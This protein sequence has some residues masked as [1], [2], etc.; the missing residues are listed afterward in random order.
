MFRDTVIIEDTIAENDIETRSW[1][2]ARQRA[3]RDNKVG[4]NTRGQ[5]KSDWDVHPYCGPHSLGET[6]HSRRSCTVTVF[7]WFLLLEELDG[8]F[9]PH[10]GRHSSRENRP[11]IPS[12]G[13]A[14][15]KACRQ[16]G[17]IWIWP[18][19]LVFVA[20]SVYAPIHVNQVILL[21]EGSLTVLITIGDNQKEGGTHFVC[22]H[23]FTFLLTSSEVPPHTSTSSESATA[24]HPPLARADLSILQRNSSRGGSDCIITRGGR[25]D[26]AGH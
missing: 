5:P 7:F 2:S 26:G 9:G 3:C 14:K 13:C 4:R 6:L 12:L 11:M 25:A 24:L 10:C 23:H 16:I 8:E 18:A 21:P 19:C 17:R 20:V 22:T 15:G 1:S